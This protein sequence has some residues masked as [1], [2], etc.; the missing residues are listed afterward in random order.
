MISI[1]KSVSQSIN[2]SI[3]QSISLFSDIKAVQC[4]RNQC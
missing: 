2:Q 4:D 1:K 3:N